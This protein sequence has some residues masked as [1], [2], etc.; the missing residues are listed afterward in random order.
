MKDD[1]PNG[2]SIE[3]TVL[4][5]IGQAASS[6][7]EPVR[8]A[9]HDAWT[10]KWL[11]VV[12]VLGLAFSLIALGGVAKALHDFRQATAAYRNETCLRGN[13]YR[14]N[15]LERWTAL[16]D[17]A[18]KADPAGSPKRAYVERR[19]AA[20]LANFQAFLLKVDAP[21]DCV[22]LAKRN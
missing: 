11:A 1:T 19:D 16:L 4:E 3:T 13:V 15:D 5:A 2:Q 21:V 14:A 17:M 20:R 7:R 6:A 12:A 10:A 9:A 18:V 8:K 22:A